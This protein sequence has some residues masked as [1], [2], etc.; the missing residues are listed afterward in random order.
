MRVVLIL[1]NYEKFDVSL[2]G[3]QW[4]FPQTFAPANR[5]SLIKD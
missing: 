2:Q 3:E 5:R 4:I 1:D